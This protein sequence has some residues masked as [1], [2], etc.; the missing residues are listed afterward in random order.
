[1]AKRAVQTVHKCQNIQLMIQAQ[2]SQGAAGHI[3]VI[4]RMHNLFSQACTLRGYPGVQLLNRDFVTLPTT[5]HHGAGGLVGAIPMRLIT[6]PGHGNAYFALGYSDVPVNNQ[7][8]E[9]P[10][11]YVMII[12]PSDYL[13]VVTYAFTHGGSISACTG[14]I[15]VSPVTATPRYR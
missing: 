3:A 14:N 7:P 8:C 11:R 13:P 12:P 9:V 2:S 10:A 5:V 4:Y 15:N 1:M 6:V